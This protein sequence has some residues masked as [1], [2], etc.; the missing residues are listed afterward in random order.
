MC[1]TMIDVC[2]FSKISQIGLQFFR[3]LSMNSSM[4][5]V[6]CIICAADCMFEVVCLSGG[7]EFHEAQKLQA[8]SSSCSSPE[9]NPGV[10][11]GR[12]GQ[13]AGRGSVRHIA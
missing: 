12:A 9:M 6:L 3:L 1:V 10:P 7:W 4:V 5:W 11:G 2:K 13:S 8:I